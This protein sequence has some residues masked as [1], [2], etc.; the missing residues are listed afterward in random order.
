MKLLAQIEYTVAITRNRQFGGFVSD[1]I[2]RS[3][4]PFVTAQDVRELMQTSPPVA[5]RTDSEAV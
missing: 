5:A 4:V 1:L 2:T 3:R